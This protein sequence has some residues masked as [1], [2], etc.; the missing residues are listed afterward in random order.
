MKTPFDTGA[1]FSTTEL[2]AA[3]G[4]DEETVKN[5]VRRG[6][7]SRAPI[8]GR[9]LR[10]RLFSTEQVYKAALTH[11]LVKLGIPPSSA[12]GAV[13]ELWKAWDQTEVEGRRI[14]AALVPTDDKWIVSMCWT[15]VSGGPLYKVRKSLAAKPNEEM[16]LPERAFAMIPISDVVAR[17]ARK[18]AD[19]LND[20]KKRTTKNARR[21]RYDRR[22]LEAAMDRL[23]SIRKEGEA[24][25]PLDDWRA[26]R[27]ARSDSRN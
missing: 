15:K 3:I 20:Q 25:S 12:S 24:S 5:W 14:Y 17:V 2:G 22:L 1:L 18:L 6:V 4:A 9:Q 27:G 23:S 7:I 19:L 13:N 10:H 26:S 11:D 8:G 21:K 16:Q